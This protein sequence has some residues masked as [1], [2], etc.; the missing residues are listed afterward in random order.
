MTHEASDPVVSV[1]IPV[2]N[3]AGN[4]APLVGEIAQ[5][6]A[7]RWSFEVICV[8]D[9]STDATAGELA[10]LMRDHPWLRQLSH[11]RSCGQSV[12][13]RSGVMAARGRVVATLDGDGQNDPA[14]LPRLIETLEAGGPHLGLVAGQRLQRQ[15]TNLKRIASRSANRVINAVLGTSARDTGCG[16]KVFRRDVFLTLPFFDGLHRFLPPLV[17]RE[18]FDIAYV[19]VVDRHRRFGKSNY[20]IWDRLWVSLADVFGVLWLTRRRRHVPAVSEVKLDAD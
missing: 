15:S 3:E 19:D 17:R 1:V 11:E 10:S 16:L 5:A 18:G 8:N 9:G 14:F 4:I 20:R 2:R 12:A 7:G 13:V 6:L